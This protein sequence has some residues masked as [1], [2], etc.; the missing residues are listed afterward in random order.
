MFLFIIIAIGV[1]ANIDNLGISMAYGLRSNRIPF[2]YNLIISIISMAA[3][4][5]SIITGNVL[6]NYLTLSFSNLIGGIL[7]IGLGLWVTLKSTN[8]T[9]ETKQLVSINWKESVVLGFILALN[10]L[11]IGFSAGIT[12]I[13]PLSTSISVGFFSFISIAIGVR[14]GHTIGNTFFGKHAE[15]IG[16]LLLILIGVFEIFI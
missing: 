13:P 9:E 6:S 5:F 16:G 4:Y 1:A 7:L 14:L 15:R 8:C 3:A 12:G 11:S 2:I 10:C